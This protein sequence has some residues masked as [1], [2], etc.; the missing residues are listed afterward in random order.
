MASFTVQTAA[1]F[2]FL[3]IDVF[4][5]FNYTNELKLAG[6]YRFFNDAANFTN[7]TPLMS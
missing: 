1:G 5:L 2:D 7:F 3:S 4:D 6:T